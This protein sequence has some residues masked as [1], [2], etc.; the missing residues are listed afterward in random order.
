MRFT[1]LISV[2]ICIQYGA[3]TN[4]LPNH[5]YNRLV[6]PSLQRR[7]HDIKISE[8]VEPLLG[9]VN[10]QT[11]KPLN[12]NSAGKI[13]VEKQPLSS[14]K[15]DEELVPSSP[16]PEAFEH[17][18]LKAKGQSDPL[19][20]HVMDHKEPIKPIKKEKEVF[21]TQIP[22]GEVSIPVTDQQLRLAALK[23]KYREEWK[24]KKLDVDQMLR[25]HDRLKLS[26]D[27][28]PSISFPPTRFQ[29]DPKKIRDS[30]DIKLTKNSKGS[31]EDPK[32]EPLL[33]L[34][35]DAKSAKPHKFTEDQL[36]W[37]LKKFKLSNQND[38]EKEKFQLYLKHY[39]GQTWTREDLEWVEGK[40][41]WVLEKYVKQWKELD[42]N[43]EKM[44]KLGG[45]LG[46]YTELD[47]V[48]FITKQSFYHL[49]TFLQNE[50]ESAKKMLKWYKKAT[51]PSLSTVSQ[52]ILNIN[53]K[54]VKKEPWWSD[55]NLRI[56]KW[57]DYHMLGGFRRFQLLIVQIG[58]VLRL[59][60]NSLEPTIE[61]IKIMKSDLIPIFKRFSYIIAKPSTRQT[62]NFP[63]IIADELDVITQSAEGDSLFSKRM[64][65]M[66]LTKEEKE[67]FSTKFLDP[68]VTDEELMRPVI[69][70]FKIQWLLNGWNPTDGYEFTSALRKLLPK[71]NSD[72]FKSLKQSPE[73]W[74]SIS[75]GNHISNG[76]L[77]KQSVELLE[78]Y[79]KLLNKPEIT[80]KIWVYQCYLGK[81]QV[82]GS[83]KD[84]FGHIARSRINLNSQRRQH[85]ETY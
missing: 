72:L 11:E 57:Y 15:E 55:D 17:G 19:V 65:S 5:S 69:D 14:I 67:T 71:S 35:I 73:L 7:M 60:E 85:K 51:L 34:G 21:K 58:D 29:K 32:L 8:E 30:S 75:P 70:T 81:I 68:H 46:L 3:I 28:V 33:D 59:G 13:F 74:N 64:E 26:S 40:P 23:S 84:G 76:K 44:I 12:G 56:W 31:K 48:E 61:E 62:H 45:L 82:T 47:E 63:T 39:I 83:M 18:T 66:D 77:S 52:K 53:L 22:S 25:L 41:R 36:K 49:N 4:G 24:E 16:E 50:P 9:H 27:G 2:C 43:E 80:K 10:L 42:L 54:H 6:S 79:S 20:G 78:F 1:V 37:Y 38:F